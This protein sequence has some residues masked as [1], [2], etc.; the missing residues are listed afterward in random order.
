MIQEPVLRNSSEAG[1]MRA[2]GNPARLAASLWERRELIR[3][4]ARNEAIGRYKGTF[5]GMVWA[6]ASPLVMLGVY[7]YVIG[8]IFGAKWD[9]QITDSRIEFS[10]TL[11][12]GLTLFT[13]FSETLSASSRCIVSNPNYVTKVVFPLEILPVVMLFS[14]LTHGLFSFLVFL[15]GLIAFVHAP[16]WTAFY[17]PLIVFLLCALTV[18]LS[19]F[20]AALG[21]F[22]RDLPHFILVATQVLFFITPI[23]YPP[24][25]VPEK[26]QWIVRLNPLAT[27]ITGARETLIWGKTP[28]WAALGAAAAVSLLIAQL[29]YMFFM[30]SRAAFGDV[31]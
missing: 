10:L 22:I 31:L 13:V 23:F 16:P 20:A 29:G 15:A 3:R 12:C 4:L 25:L 7:T 17:F 2:H 21:V 1:A 18:G 26:A 19:W 28:D 8:G 24:S 30:K 6:F 9:S 27:L 14:S 11:F 5:F